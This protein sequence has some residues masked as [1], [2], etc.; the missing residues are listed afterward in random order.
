MRITRAFHR[1]SLKA[2]LISS[3][4]VVLGIGGLA[5]SIVGSW[6]VS[7][8]IM[9]Q[10]R[11]K[12]D[13]DLATAGAIY[14]QQL[15][16]VKCTVQLVA[17]AGRIQR[18]L[19]LSDSASAL[20][21]LNQLKRDSNLDFLTLADRRGRVI[22]RATRPTNLGDDVSTISV[23][24]AAL[25]GRVAAAAEIFPPERLANEDPVLSER[26]HFRLVDTPKAK[27]SDKAEETSG[28]VLVAGAPL[29]SPSGDILG[30]LYGGILLSRDFGIVDG[31]WNLIYAGERFKKR[32]V[33]TVTIL[34]NDLRISTNVRTRTGERALGTRVSENVHEA[35]LTRGKT[36]SDRAFV[37]DDWYVSGYR[38]IRNYNGDIIG[39]LCVGVLEEAF[40]SIHN[41]II[42]AF[43]GIAAVG[44]I[45]II[46]VTY[47]MVNDITRP[48]V[49]MVEA[50][51]NIAAGH[52]DQE[53]HST[54]EDEIGQ[55]AASFNT[56]LKSVR[57]AQGQCEQW[58][59]TLEEKV[60]ERTQELVA[61]QATVVR[62]DRLASL[63]KLAAGVAHEINN[64][65]GGILS[66]TSLTLEDMRADDPNREN[67]EEVIR[68]SERCRD[69]V[70]GLLEFSRQPEA[71]PEPVAVND[72]LRDTL[73]LLQKQSIFFNIEVVS[74]WA[75]RLPPIMADKAQLQQVFMNVIL[76]A[77]Q[78]MNEKGTVTIQTRCRPAGGVVEMV[79]SDTGCGIPP[80]KID[81]VFDPF[82]TTKSSG[83]G[84]GLGLSI[85]YGIV[86]K[87]GG[88]ISIDSEVGKGSTI[89]IR[90]PSMADAYEESRT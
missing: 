11:S 77:V 47:Y 86:T 3:Y 67:L 26:A 61:M 49:E 7:S 60:K 40:T 85:A 4:L 33:G 42:M 14:E 69:I 48:I 36:W 90:L 75:G 27:W 59:R 25:A 37:V 9:Q 28:M 71:E 53:V 12:I 18:D 6:I 17:S 83:R 50:T 84:T 31:V 35:V 81:R 1:L 70:K 64:P 24:R 23:V 30:V 22:M 79:F 87:H 39:I 51:R 65:L 74:D 56:M 58:G 15:Q 10:T 80:D 76:N 73:S 82:F 29:Q 34:Q 44:F 88:T 16:T 68:Q 32:E 57:E 66:L 78:A 62:T 21:Y 89:T 63:G 8:T 38:P 5:T 72:V 55:L 54:S 45:M 13:D 46:A 2:K 20:A 43:F 52:L 19:S 41:R